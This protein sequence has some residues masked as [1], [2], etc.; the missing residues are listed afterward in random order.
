M[1]RML[2]IGWRSAERAAIAA[3]LAAGRAGSAERATAERNA[4]EA[5]LALGVAQE[6]YRQYMDALNRGPG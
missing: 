4:G 5:L 2:L 3:E 1:A 6:R